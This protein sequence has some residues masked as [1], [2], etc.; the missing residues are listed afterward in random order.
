[1]LG[2]TSLEVYNSIY[3]KTEENNK[4]ELY[5]FPDDKSGAIS[6]E[7]VREEI[8]KDLDITDITAT[9][10]Q[11]EIIVPVIID[12]YRE[13]VTKRIEDGA[14][15]NFLAGYHTSV[16]QDF[17]ACLRTKIDLVENDIRLVL[18]KHNSNFLTYEIQPGIHNSK[19]LSSALFN[20]L[21]PEHPASSNVIVIEFDDITEKTKLVVKSGIIAIRYDEKLFFNTIFGFTAGWDYNHYNEYVS[22]KIVNSSGTN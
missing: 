17:E 11:D 10:L 3:N 6:F 14:L 4:I 18:D 13:Q 16:F 5:K 8:E 12:E 9:D 19:D 2:F 1:M 7:K 20:I 21:Q 15:M 22:Q